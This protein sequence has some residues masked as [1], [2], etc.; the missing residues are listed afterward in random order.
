M[1]DNT[2][3]MENL[4]KGFITVLVV[5]LFFVLLFKFARSADTASSTEKEY[6]ENLQQHLTSGTYQPPVIELKLSQ[7]QIKA[8]EMLIDKDYL[9]IENR[10]DAYINPL[11]WDTFDIKKKKGFAA[12]LAKYC[13]NKSFDKLELARICDKQTGKLLAKYDN[14]EFEVF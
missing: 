12:M 5:I 13:E 10:H 3:V 14:G 11:M 1:P 6:Q 9:F 2:K 4:L 8:I 7:E